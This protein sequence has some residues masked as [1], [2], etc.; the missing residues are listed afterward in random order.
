MFE[1][2]PGVEAYRSK[3]LIAPCAS[4]AGKMREALENLASLS[5]EVLEGKEVYTSK[6]FKQGRRLNIFAEKNGAERALDML[7]Q[8]VRGEPYGT[9]VPQPNFERVAPAPAVKDLSQT[10]IALISTG[11]VV[12]F[13]NPE[14]MPTG[15][16]QK[17]AIC[18]IAGLD[19]FIKGDWQTV[20]A[21]YDVSFIDDDPD[22]LVPL[23][24]V[25]DLVK[26]GEIGA[27][28][29]KYLYTVGNTTAVAN[30]KKFGEEM[31]DY[32]RQNGV[33][34]AIMTST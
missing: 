33:S 9:E 18:D 22:R 14:R 15:N 3:V 31:A 13:G 19:G 27:I 29:D 7:L 30:A 23:D 26:Q 2:N 28:H 5:R 34:A 12:P 25:I 1:E 10:K 24:V 6:Y 21:G 17:W 11:G 4:S 16:A 32:L 20:H 8:K